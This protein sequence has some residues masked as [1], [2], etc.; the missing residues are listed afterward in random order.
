MKRAARLGETLGRSLQALPGRHPSV[1]S[2]FGEG[3][4]WFV[5]LNEPAGALAED[6]WGGDGTATSLAS[7]V[8]AATSS[9]G[10]VIREFSGEMLWL[11]PPLVIDERDPEVAV[12]VLD[13]ALGVA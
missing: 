6:V 4:M 9:V 5:R 11:V 3:L 2:V 7:T 12:E 8:S 13:E 1:R 10:V